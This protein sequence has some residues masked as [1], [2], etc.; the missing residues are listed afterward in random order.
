MPFTIATPRIL[1][2]L[3]LARRPLSGDWQ[4]RCRLEFYTKFPSKLFP[5][6]SLPTFV[7][8]A[9]RRRGL[10][11]ATVFPVQNLRT[12]M[13]Q[14]GR[15]KYIAG[16]LSSSPFASM[17]P[18]TVSVGRSTL[19]DSILIESF[20]VCASFRMLGPICWGSL[21]RSSMAHRG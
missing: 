6:S 15:H 3:A 12:H 2:M 18:C 4:D 20:G 10:A 9:Q 19:V 16:P 5:F 13:I 1:P 8:S 11:A 21:V 14:R 17:R 7:M